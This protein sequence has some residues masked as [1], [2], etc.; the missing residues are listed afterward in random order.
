MSHV[1]IYLYTTIFIMIL[2][3]QIVYSVCSNYLFLCVCYDRK[4][5]RIVIKLC[6]SEDKKYN[7]MAVIT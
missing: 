1:Y 5:F 3:C 4:R 6:C 2:M 7:K